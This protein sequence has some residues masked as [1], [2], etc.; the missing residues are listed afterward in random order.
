MQPLSFDPIREAINSGELERAGLLW[1]AFA[2]G[3]AGEYAAG[4]LTPARMAEIRE[5]VA[6]SRTVFLCDQA[7]L[8]DQLRRL[9]SELRVESGYQYP[10]P[11]VAP[12]FVAAS[13]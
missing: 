1:D 7:H 6:W 5:L 8:Q 12:Q 9:E 3:L 10:D 13:F 11:A 4:R 2:S